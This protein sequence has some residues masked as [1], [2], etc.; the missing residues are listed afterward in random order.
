MM[1]IQQ[2][3]SA[4]IMVGGFSG[5]DYLF[6][7]VVVSVIRNPCEQKTDRDIPRIALVITLASLPGDPLPTQ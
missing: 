6:K 3:L 2:P 1:W 5:N 4:L 7:R